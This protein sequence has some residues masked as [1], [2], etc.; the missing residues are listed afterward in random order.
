M[1]I[2]K[3]LRLWLTPSKMCRH[4]CLWCEYAPVCCGEVLD[5]DDK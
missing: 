2:W 1:K 3:R 5:E 4:C